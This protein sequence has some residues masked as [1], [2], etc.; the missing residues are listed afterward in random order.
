MCISD[1]NKHRLV[2]VFPGLRGKVYF[3]L[4]IVDTFET[5]CSKTNQLKSVVPS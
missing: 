1:K 3:S 4:V 2:H 5:H